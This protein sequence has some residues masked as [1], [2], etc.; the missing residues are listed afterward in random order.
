M[1]KAQLAII[2]LSQALAQHRY[3]A[4]LAWNDV[5]ARY[6]GSLIGP[7]WLTLN[8][9]LLIGGLGFLYTQLLNQEAERYIPYLAVGIL[10][11]NFMTGTLVECCAAYIGS[12]AMIKQIK[13]PM[14]GYLVQILWRNLIVLAHHLI[15]LVVV[16]LYFRL[17][18][19]FATIN[20]LPG[21]IL[22]FANMI[23]MG[24]ALAILCARYRDISP[25]AA[26][27]FQLAFFLS[28]ILWDRDMLKRHYWLADYNPLY[29]MLEV[30]RSPILGRPVPEGLWT[31][32]LAVLFIG[33]LIAAGLFSRYRAQIVYWI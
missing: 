6:R 16:V 19:S 27:F 24:I 5:K 25:I 26:S 3:W 22:L 9:G 21:F 18:L 28:P 7:Y 2:D 11:W 31:V 23:W 30:V 32:A 8:T 33:S 17:P 13:L 10:L 29:A 12:A 4:S 20:A 15:I 1:T 14:L